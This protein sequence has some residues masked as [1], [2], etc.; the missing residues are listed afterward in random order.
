MNKKRQ[1]HH[2]DLRRALLDAALEVIQAQGDAGLTLRGVARVAGVSHA[3][4]YHHFKDK[5]GLLA[6]VAEEGFLELQRFIA[7]RSKETVHPGTSLQEAAVAYVIFAVENPELFRVM[8]DANL[9]DKDAHPSLQEASRTAYRTIE[10]GLM[11]DSD[12]GAREQ[13]ADL[14][15]AAWAVIH[16]L[17]ILLVDNQL[18][19]QDVKAAERLARRTT[20]IFW[21][22]L[23]RYGSP[24]DPPPED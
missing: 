7:S 6:A 22:G 20:D 4:P 3:A 11:P 10:Q 12:G 19:Q 13:A 24:G 14:A 18:G 21:E 2:G 8:F 15:I 17:A 1:Y 9:Y 16:G 5:E 23:S